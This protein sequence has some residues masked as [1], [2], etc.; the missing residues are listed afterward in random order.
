[1]NEIHGKNRHEESGVKETGQVSE[2][3]QQSQE[4]VSQS[5]ESVT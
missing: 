4:E 3:S 2:S 1:L 5:Y